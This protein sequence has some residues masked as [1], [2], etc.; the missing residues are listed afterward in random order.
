MPSKIFLNLPVKNLSRSVKFFTEVGFTFNPHF[1]DETSTC[2]IISESIFVMLLEESKFKTFVKKPVSDAVQFAELIIALD[3][4][5]R[6]QVDAIVQ[7][8]VDAGATTPNDKQDLGF[9]YVSGFQDLDGHLWEIM[10]MDP[11][12]VPQG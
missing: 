4:E 11:A 7:K 1:T 6:E 2:M 5:S 8:A 10:W 12:A 9:L 3:A